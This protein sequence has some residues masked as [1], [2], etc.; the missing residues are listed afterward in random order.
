MMSMAYLSSHR[1]PVLESVVPYDTTTFNAANTTE[2]KNNYSV[3]ETNLYLYDSCQANTNKAISD[4]KNLIVNNGA[5]AA[6]IYYDNSY[7]SSDGKSYYYD[8]TADANHGVTIVGWDDNYAASNFKT[9]PSGNGAWLIKNSYGTSVNDAGYFYASYYDHHIC[10][11]I[12]TVNNISDVTY[13][14]AYYYDVSGINSSLNASESSTTTLYFKTKFSKKSSK[15]E[16]LKQVTV[17]TYA[18]GDSYTLYYSSDGTLANSTE[19][20]EETSVGFGYQS[21]DLTSPISLTTSDYYILEKYNSST[22][23]FPSN[24]IYTTLSST[25][26]DLYYVQNPISGVSFYSSDALEWLDTITT[27]TTLQ[28]YNTIH[29]FTDVAPASISISSSSNSGNVS[30]TDGGYYT[31]NLDLYNISSVSD[32]TVKIIDENNQDKTSL[33]DITPITSGYKIAIKPGETL[34]GNYTVSF[35][36]GTVSATDNIA[37]AA[38]SNTLVTEVKING[39]NEVAVGGSLILSAVVNPTSATNTN[40]IWSSSDSS[41]AT[42]NNGIVSGIKAGTVKITATSED[43]AKKA[44]Y[45]T[46]TVIDTKKV[47]TIL[48]NTK[49][50]SDSNVTESPKTGVKSITLSLLIILIISAIAYYFAKRK[51]FLKKY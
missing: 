27:S 22:Y 11:Q 31:Y 9:T 23:Q 28:F 45:I 41:I 21:I 26:N 5:E 12:L 48:T 46:I 37:V 14:N 24:L 3:K 35:I 51:D 47:E 40:V 2:L 17:G 8:G 36:Y 4:I 25:S 10:S 33:F 29:A 15:T 16:L 49:I 13:D 1:G 7:L 42:V 30:A 6:E 32:V 34:A 19:I 20:G 43:A 38:N 50:G 44:D 18:A 39:S